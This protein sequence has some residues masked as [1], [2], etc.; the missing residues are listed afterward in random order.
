MVANIQDVFS[1]LVKNRDKLKNLGVDKLGIFGSFTENQQNRDS[2][3]DLLVEFSKGKKNYK[4]F[5]NTANLVESIL[6]R[7]IDLVTPESLSKY[8]GPH[9]I[10][11]TQ[12]VQ[13][14]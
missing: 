13:I 14:T 2:D 9:I 1:A 7:K 5:I 3:V 10:K 11:S 8:I 4:N 12:Y 6:D